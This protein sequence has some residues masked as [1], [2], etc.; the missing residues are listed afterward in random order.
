[1][2][3][4]LYTQT[5]AVGNQEKLKTYVFEIKVE[6]ND[7]GRWSADCPILPGCATW[8][9][10]RSEALHNIREAV[11]GYVTDMIAAGEPV[12]GAADVLDRPAVSVTV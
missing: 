11:E 6:Q 9:R 7:D 12:P 3:V 4:L 8:G 1:M 10:T 2:Y 5:T